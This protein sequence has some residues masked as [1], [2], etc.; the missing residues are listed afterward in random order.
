M[1]LQ[2]KILLLLTII[3][4]V[5]IFTF[6][7]FQYIRIREKKLLYTENLKSQELVVDKVLELNRI[8]YEQLTNDNSS[9]DEMVDFA[10]KPDLFWAKDNVDFF[11]NSFNLSF[12]RIYNKEKNPIYQFGDSLSLKQMELPNEKMIEQLFTNSVFAHYFQYSGNELFEIFGATI[13]PAAD[14]N[15]R[16]SPAFGYL[17]IG[18]KWDVKY[19]ASHGLATNYHAEVIPASEISSF[20]FES[21]KNY[22]TRDLRNINGQFIAKLIF[23]REDPLKSDLSLFLILSVV[24]ILTAFAAIIVFLLYFRNLILKPLSLISK[25]LKTRNAEHLNSVNGNTNEF[26]KIRSL[27]Q[28]FFQQEELLKTSNIEL[29]ETNATKDKL[30]SIIAHDLKNPIGNIQVISILL[31]ESIKNNEKE[32][33]E[34]LLS[35][36][37]SQTKET[38]ALLETLFDWA[39]SQTG[40][41]NFSPANLNLKETI[42]QIIEIHQPSAI[43]KDI[44]IE[45]TVPA[46]TR[47]FADLNMLKTILRNLITNAIKFTHQGGFIKITADLKSNGTEI[48]VSDNGI[49]MD[50]NTLSSLFQIDNSKTT[51]GTSNEKGTGLGLIICKEFIEKHGGSIKAESAPGKGTSFIFFMPET[52]I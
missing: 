50:D 34:E 7:T 19:I 12:V 39:K 46:E 16:K 15:T 31:S 21:G 29:K 36:I 24:L 41:F 23:S 49:G 42:G 10:A 30:F 8:K 32:T 13:V 11:V 26:K 18:Q 35:M 51:K 1:K 40:Q 48:T 37:S 14:A 47:V 2:V 9:W 6:L 38:M 52:S 44:S 4:G 45:S 22:L 33:S 20:R 5:I 27:I 3:F 25:T 28:Q 43:L 17:L